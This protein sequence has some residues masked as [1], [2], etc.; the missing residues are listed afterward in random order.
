[1]SKHEFLSNLRTDKL[2]RLIHVY[3]LEPKL[4]EIMWPGREDYIKVLVKSRKATIENIKKVL[5]L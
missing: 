2:E 4:A 3:D 5:K 1:M